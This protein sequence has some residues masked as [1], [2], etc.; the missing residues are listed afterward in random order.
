MM[1]LTTTTE[2]PQKEQEQVHKVQIQGE[3]THDADLHE[4]AAIFIESGIS[5][6]TLDFLGI[7]SGKDGEYQHASHA[8]NQI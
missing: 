3:R 7:I 2:E 5:R 8:D 4:Q 6:P 1:L